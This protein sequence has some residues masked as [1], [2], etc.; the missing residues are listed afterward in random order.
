MLIG[1]LLKLIWNPANVERRREF[2]HQI[3]D[4]LELPKR[5]GFSSYDGLVIAAWL[6]EKWPTRVRW[7][8]RALNRSTRVARMRPAHRST[9]YAGVR[10]ADV[11]GFVFT[12]SDYD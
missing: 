4:E 9:S 3:E 1:K 5:L 8:V 6:L 7:A 11:I 10:D 2:L 12:G